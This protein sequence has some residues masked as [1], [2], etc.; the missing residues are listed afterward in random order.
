MPSRGSFDSS[1]EKLSL[2]GQATHLR[3][4]VYSGWLRGW[5]LREQLQSFTIYHLRGPCLELALVRLPSERPAAADA[6][7]GGRLLTILRS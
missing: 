6:G 3:I 1:T 7:S 4:V 5:Q 2:V